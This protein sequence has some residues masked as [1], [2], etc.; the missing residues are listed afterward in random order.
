MDTSNSTDSHSS[1]EWLFLSIPTDELPMTITSY[2]LYP[3]SFP[4][5]SI[6]FTATQCI[7]RTIVTGFKL[8][9]VANV[10]PSNECSF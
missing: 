7:K 8:K 10:S 5:P 6:I 3:S 1:P 2:F 4:P 9:V